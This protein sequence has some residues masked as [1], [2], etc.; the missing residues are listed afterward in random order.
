MI[1][2]KQKDSSTDSSCEVGT[3]DDGTSTNSTDSTNS[4]TSSTSSTG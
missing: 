2:A 4:S 1:Q 3:S